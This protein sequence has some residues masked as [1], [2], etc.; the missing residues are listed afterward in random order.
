MAFFSIFTLEYKWIYVAAS[1]S[2]G[3]TDKIVSILYC[4]S[5][6]APS[7]NTIYYNF[8]FLIMDG[9][10]TRHTPSPKSTKPMTLTMDVKCTGLITEGVLDQQK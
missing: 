4:I 3:L 1:D 9:T 5:G 10:S 7:W 2:I 8:Y 6:V